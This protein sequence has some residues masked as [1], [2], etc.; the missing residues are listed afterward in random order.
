VPA[1]EPE[2]AADEEPVAA[3]GA[4]PA[5]VRAAQRLVA[6]SSARRAAGVAEQADGTQP[7]RTAKAAV[8]QKHASRA[9]SVLPEQAPA[10]AEEKHGTAQAGVETAA[11]AAVVAAGE[12][13]ATAMRVVKAMTDFILNFCKRISE[14]KSGFRK[15]RR[16]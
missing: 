11:G 13:A 4:A 8:P 5:P 10:L 1:A 9:V 14:E 12:A 16:D 6:D 2:A 7:A 15:K 3:A